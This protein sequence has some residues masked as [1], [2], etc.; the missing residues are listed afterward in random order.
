[1]KCQRPVADTNFKCVSVLN[2]PLFTN[3]PF[4]NPSKYLWMSKSLEVCGGP[5]VQMQLQQQILTKAFPLR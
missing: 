5:D 3:R 2:P 1:M 4:N